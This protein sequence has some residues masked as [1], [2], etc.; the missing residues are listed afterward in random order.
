MF[1][2]LRVAVDRLQHSVQDRGDVVEANLQ[3]RLRL[4]ALDLERYAP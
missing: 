4:D 1:E 3:Q 2:D